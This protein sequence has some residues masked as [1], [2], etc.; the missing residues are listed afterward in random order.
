[1][2]H[3]I[4]PIGLSEVQILAVVKVNSAALTEKNLNARV[5]KNGFQ[6][7]KGALNMIWYF[8]YASAVKCNFLITALTLPVIRLKPSE[9]SHPDLFFH[10][11]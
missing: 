2:G 1:M 11:I 5:I 6:S 4:W 8:S 9:A 7:D 10:R 3:M